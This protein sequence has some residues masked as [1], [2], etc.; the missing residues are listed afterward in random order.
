MR[1][2]S[3]PGSSPDA[4][5]NCTRILVVDDEEP[6]VALLS[7]LLS[8]QNYTVF[9]ALDGESAL[10]ILAEEPIDLVLLDMMMPRMDGIEVCSHVRNVMGRRTLPI[11]F[12]TALSD[13]ESRV[14]GKAAGADDFLVKPIDVLEL[15]VRVENLLRLSAY[16]KLVE[17]GQQELTTELDRAARRIQE[18]E[19]LSTLGSLAAGVGAELQ[20]VSDIHRGALEQLMQVAEQKGTVDAALVQRFK[21]VGLLL[22]EHAAHLTNLG[23]PSAEEQEELEL[24]TVVTSAVEL[25]R[26]TGRL[27]GVNVST[28]LARVSPR[29]RLS[30][31]R[32]QQ[33]MV[34]LLLNAVD[35][36]D[37]RS[38]HQGALDVRVEPADPLGRVHVHVIDN[39]VG[40]NAQDLQRVFEPY[41]ST[42]PHARGMGL[43]LTLVRQIVESGGGRVVLVSRPDQGTTASVDF[44]ALNSDNSL[45]MPS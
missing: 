7:S 4:A 10:S 43:G 31:T 39:G 25:V 17:K 27:E 2:L 14:R 13:R 42:K 12:T 18:L 28:D 6:N 5:P 35:A 3:S 34:N 26:G 19:R 44:P 38:D 1:S 29:I 30:R 32:F 24:N 23:G 22:S 15:F 8:S 20:T 33:V 11:V 16:H 41:F 45:T 36:L 37:A 21:Q 9:T 40:I